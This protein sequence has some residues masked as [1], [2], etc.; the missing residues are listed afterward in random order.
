LYVVNLFA[1]RSTDPKLLHKTAD[2]VGPENEV[3]VAR[4]ARESALIVCAWS[5]HGD[6]QAHRPIARVW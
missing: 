2:P 6:Y 5:A 3:H 4:C 1:L